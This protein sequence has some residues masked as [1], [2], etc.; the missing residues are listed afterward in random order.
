MAI[1]KLRGFQLEYEEYG[2]GDKYLLCC[3]QG[4][5]KV[6]N[7]TMELA[8]HGFHVF[9]IVIRGY[10]QSTHVTG[11]YGDDWYDIWAQD[12]CDFADAMGI[13]RFYYTGVSHGAGIGWHICINHPQR[14]KAFFSIVGGPHS[15]DGQETGSARMAVIRAAAT[16]ESWEAYCDAC[17][18]AEVLTRPAAISDEDWQLRLRFQKEQQAGRRNMSLEEARLNPRKPFARLHSEA[19]L[20]A[21]LSKIH[22][23]VL[24]MGGMHDPICLPENLIRS[25][26]AVKG[27]K[28]VI[29]E[30]A[31]HGLDNE[32]VA[33]VVNEI[34]LFCK[35]R[36]LR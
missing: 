13:D 29:F 15:K 27:S 3:Q 18:A 21:E 34:L 11:D 10:G 19:E 31:S 33:E 17:E 32:H 1:C 22:L 30:D 28:L 14:V 6:I 16:Q 7:W 5:S 12:A 35:E 4:H 20:V 23:P 36:D 8:R 2:S 24:M 9:D 26:R 25:C